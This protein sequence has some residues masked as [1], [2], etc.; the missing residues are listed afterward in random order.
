MKQTIAYSSYFLIVAAVTYF[1]ELLLSIFIMGILF[2]AADAPPGDISETAKLVYS[3]GMPVAYASVLFGLYYLYTDIL[4]SFS[5]HLRLGVGVL[6]H[7]TIAIYL[8]W[9]VVPDAFG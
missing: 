6:F 7:I 4:K 9:N 2:S 3:V 8:I 5:T 1:L